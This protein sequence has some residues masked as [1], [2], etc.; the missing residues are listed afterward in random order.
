MGC[1]QCHQIK[2]PPPVRKSGEVAQV[3]QM[4]KGQINVHN[5]ELELYKQNCRRQKLTETKCICLFYTGPDHYMTSNLKICLYNYWKPIWFCSAHNTPC[6]LCCAREKQE[7]TGMCRV[8]LIVVYF[9]VRTVRS[10]YLVF[11]VNV[12]NERDNFGS[13]WL[14]AKILTIITLS[15]PVSI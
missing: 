4:A 3:A 6:L 5:C 14:F 8:T 7:Q 12:L 2:L 1:G 11:I 10:Y 15:L 13:V 9:C